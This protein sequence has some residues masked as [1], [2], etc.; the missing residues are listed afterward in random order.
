LPIMSDPRLIDLIP[1]MRNLNPKEIPWIKSRSNPG[2]YGCSP[3]RN[4]R[5]STVSRTLPI[6]TRTWHPL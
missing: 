4:F 3:I 5:T 2:G 6:S 1:R